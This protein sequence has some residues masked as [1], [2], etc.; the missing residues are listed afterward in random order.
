MYS[1]DQ[2]QSKWRL[3]AIMLLVLGL[4]MDSLRAVQ[5]DITTPSRIQ[6]MTSKTPGPNPHTPVP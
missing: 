3:L 2:R 6:L 1:T 5:G 4:F